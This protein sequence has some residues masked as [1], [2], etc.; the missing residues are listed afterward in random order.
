VYDGNTPEDISTMSSYDMTQ[1]VHDVCVAFTQQ[2][3]DEDAMWHPYWVKIGSELTALMMQR[4]RIEAHLCGME[5]GDSP[6]IEAKRAILRSRLKPL[7]A[8]IRAAGGNPDNPGAIPERPPKAVVA[9]Q[10]PAAPLDVPQIRWASAFPMPRNAAGPTMTRA[11]DGSFRVSDDV[12][13]RPPPPP[14]H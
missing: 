4:N 8:R 11:A 10:P 9:T 3:D 2:L 6:E 5:I 13:L 14:P 1:I 7:L 12:P